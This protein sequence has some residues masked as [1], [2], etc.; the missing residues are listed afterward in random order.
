MISKL[1]MKS[2]FGIIVITT[3]KIIGEIIIYVSIICQYSWAVDSFDINK[4]LGHS[5]MPSNAAAISPS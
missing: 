5:T 3:S 4:P 1:V 2:A